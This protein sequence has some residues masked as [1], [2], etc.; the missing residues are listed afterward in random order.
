MF[1]VSLFA[2]LFVGLAQTS[3]AVTAPDQQILAAVAGRRN[4]NF[5]QGTGMTVVKILPEDRNGL[6]HQL[7]VVRLS[8]GQEM[9]AVSNLDMCP[10]IPLKVGDVVSMGGQFIWTKQGPLLHWL[11]RDPKKKRPDGYVQLAGRTYCR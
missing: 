11:H 3:F 6:P 4:V 9:T 10:S 8:N 5:V 1:K 2:I 7:W